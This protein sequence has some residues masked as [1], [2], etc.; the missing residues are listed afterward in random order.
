MDSSIAPGIISDHREKTSGIPDLLS[1]KGMNVSFAQLKTGDYRLNNNLI[2]ERKS[3]VDFIQ[4]IIS[5]RLFNQCAKLNKTGLRPYILLEGNPYQ[6]SH[7]IDRRA[8]KGALISVIS[9]WQIPVI[10][11]KNTE[12]S[13]ATLFILSKQTLK[14]NDFL[15]KSGYKPKTI[16]NQKLKFLQG[17]PKVGSVMALRLLNHFGSIQ[18]IVEADEK[19][20]IKVKGIGNNTAK[21]IYDFVK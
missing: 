8:V 1:Q 11:S 14:Q 17:L 6:T 18:K 5:G 2:I 7:Q 3:A 19:S 15:R 9:S 16:K 20:L 13:A 21:K 12:D 10:H 4:S